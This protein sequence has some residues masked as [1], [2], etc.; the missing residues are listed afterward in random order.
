MKQGSWTY[1]SRVQELLA[2]KW[3]G[4]PSPGYFDSLTKDERLDIIALYVFEN[5]MTAINNYEDSLEIKRSRKKP[6]GRR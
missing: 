3:W 2:A 5:K 1:T 4:C 6:K